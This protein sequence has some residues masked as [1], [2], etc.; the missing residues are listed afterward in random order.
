MYVIGAWGFTSFKKLYYPNESI[1]V[2]IGLKVVIISDIRSVIITVFR[3]IKIFIAIYKLVDLIGV[4]WIEVV[5]LNAEV[6]FDTF[7]KDFR[8]ISVNLGGFR[9]E[10]QV[11]ITFRLRKFLILRQDS[12]WLVSKLMSLQNFSQLACDS[13]LRLPLISFCNWL[14]RVFTKGSC[15]W[16]CC[17][18]SLRFT[19]ISASDSSTAGWL[20]GRPLLDVGMALSTAVLKAV[21]IKSAYLSISW[22]DLRSGR[23][24]LSSMP[25]RGL[26]QTLLCRSG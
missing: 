23:S 15:A 12:V 16:E 8:L 13:V 17:R 20:S 19:L 2:N 6:S 11:R 14:I 26:I 4:V 18:L 1:R 7:G 25:S 24:R 3:R 10:S 21:T 5:T 22:V 9:I